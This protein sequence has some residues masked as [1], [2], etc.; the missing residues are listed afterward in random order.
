MKR[1]FRD[2]LEGESRYDYLMAK[3]DWHLAEADK[4]DAKRKKHEDSIRRVLPFFVVL[5]IIW[6]VAFV[7]RVL[8]DFA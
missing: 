3:A 6:L 7:V 5:V 8:I 4:Y 2:P 1:N